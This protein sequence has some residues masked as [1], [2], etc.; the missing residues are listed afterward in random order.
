MSYTINTTAG[1]TI[2]RHLMTGT[3]SSP[4]WSP[5]GR[6]VESSDLEKAYDA[7]TIRD[8]LGDVY[9]MMKSPI[10]TQSFDP[11]P[12]DSGDAAAVKLWQLDTIDEDPQALANQD[13]LIAHYYTSDGETSPKSFAERYPNSA[14]EPSRLG[15][16]GG[17]NLTMG[18][19]VTCGG[20]R[21]VGGVVNNG[22]TV[23]FTAAS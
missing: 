7:S 2:A 8:V 1:Q 18:V 15:G 22:G 17:D 5:V 23:T 13:I 14:L 20:A 12:L 4:A 3:S 6:R 16:D 9:T 10:K 11:W 19:T 21:S